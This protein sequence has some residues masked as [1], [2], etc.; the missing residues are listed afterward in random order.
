MSKKLLLEENEYL[1]IGEAAKFLGIS[2]KTLF[3]WDKSGKFT[4]SFTTLIGKHRRYSRKDLEAISGKLVRTDKYI[5]RKINDLVVIKRLPP[6]WKNEILYLCRCYCGKEFEVDSRHL[7]LVRNCGCSKIPSGILGYK[8]KVMPN[9]Y[10]YLYVP[11]HLEALVDGWVPEHLYVMS[12]KLGR[13][14]KSDE[15]IHHKNGMLADNREENLELWTKNM[16]PVGMRIED[17]VEA[18]FKILKEYPNY[19]D[20]ARF[21]ILREIYNK[22]F[23]K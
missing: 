20:E 17:V 6:G 3:R 23:K 2:N 9:G 8:R 1:T 7:P 16:P 14:L 18:S 10:A 22:R 15:F 13:K 12:N 21:N 19:L 5:G 4:N 11:E